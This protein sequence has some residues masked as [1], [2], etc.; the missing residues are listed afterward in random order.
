M[1]SITDIWSSRFRV[2]PH[3]GEALELSPVA[4]A[5]LLS[6]G[7]WMEAP[8]WINLGV[9]FL[10]WWR[11]ESRRVARVRPETAGY[12]R[13][14]N[15]GFLPQDPPDSWGGDVLALESVGQGE[16]AGGMW[17]LCAYRMQ[18]QAGRRRWYFIGFRGA[19][20]MAWSVYCDQIALNERLARSGE[21]L[22][23][24]E[25]LD[26][27]SQGLIVE[28]T[29]PA[30]Q[31]AYLQAVRFLFAASYYLAR[32][33]LAHVSVTEASGPVD[34][35]ARGK[36]LRRDGRPVSLWTY[37]DLTVSRLPAGD[38]E[39]RGP[40]DTAHLELRPV[41]VRPYIRRHADGHVVI[42]DAHGSHRWTRPDRMGGKIKI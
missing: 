22:A 29:P 9:A 24:G 23:D 42:V 13:G 39:G 41:V 19:D 5:G 4:G 6:D 33:D 17:S 11:G 18:D 40:V 12:L 10:L 2:S 37:Q 3:L 20:A 14:V 28:P 34:R 7:D 15:L 32:P 25:V 36:A 26:D 38:G 21:F 27:M 1:Q 35:D 31:L 8:I 16:L 30:R